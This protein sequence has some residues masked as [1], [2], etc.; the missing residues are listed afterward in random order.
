MTPDNSTIDDDSPGRRSAAAGVYVH[1]PFCL[2][3]CPYCDFVSYATPKPAEIDHA[4]YADAVLK[5]L[6]IRAPHLSA[7]NVDTVFFGGGTPSLW[8]PAQL[9][10][11][12][13]GIRNAFPA[14]SDTVAALEVTVECNPTSLDEDRARAL[15]D[16][17]VNRVSIGV[18]SLD[19][20]RLRHLGR[21]HNADGGR[22]AVRGA[23]RAGLR[24]VSADLIFGLPRQT[25]EAARAEARELA[26]LGLDHVSCYQL[27]IEAGTRFGELA[28]R[29]RLPLAD[30]GEVADSF[31]SVDEG[32]REAGF[33]HYEVSN[34][35]RPGEEARHNLGYWRGHEYLG[36]GC[37][38]V[39]FVRRQGDG[40]RAGIRY[41]NTTIPDRFVAAARDAKANTPGADDGISESSEDLDAAAL[42]RERIMLGLRVD[43]GVDIEAA[44]Q[45]LG[46]PGWTTDRLRAASL[47]EDRGRIVREG[48]K[49]RIPAAAWLWTD[50]TAARLL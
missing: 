7:R 13:D 9:G 32:L 28:R 38:A 12:L 11:V 47:L 22:E 34:F 44:A 31:L 10:R 43:E 3:K 42:L 40:S 2:A 41:R 39:G 33:R 5:E 50:D 30:E 21:L 25:P 27:T 20:G 1:F 15:A 29:G 24:R 26:D 17:G 6:D 36:L 49:V 46:T 4:G 37:A 35:A 45:A 16:V 23:L 19:D 14:A 8:E 18:Q 48:G